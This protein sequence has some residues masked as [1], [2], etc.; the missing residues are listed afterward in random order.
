MTVIDLRFRDSNK[1]FMSRYVISNYELPTLILNTSENIQ[2]TICF[3][4]N[5]AKPSSEYL[6]HFQID[7]FL[8]LYSICIF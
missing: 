8:C 2:E 4:P 5:S 6:D 1:R 7:V 3:F